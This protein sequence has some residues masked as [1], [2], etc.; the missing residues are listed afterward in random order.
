MSDLVENPEGR[1]SR[2][3]AQSIFLSDEIPIRG[4]IGHLEEGGFLP[5]THKIYLWAHLHFNL[6]YSGD[7]IIYA[8]VSTKEQSPVSLD[9]VSAPFEVAFTYSVKW[10]ESK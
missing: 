2:D 6:E 3:E 4:F 7:Q 5:H 8:N 9:G 10:I 1:F